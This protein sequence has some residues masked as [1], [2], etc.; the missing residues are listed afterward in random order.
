MFVE[1]KQFLSLYEILIFKIIIQFKKSMISSNYWFYF[2]YTLD[3]GK[4]NIYL[5]LKKYWKLKIF[6]LFNLIYDL[7]RLSL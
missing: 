4:K 3:K 7:K 5:S 1:L 2:V 6:M